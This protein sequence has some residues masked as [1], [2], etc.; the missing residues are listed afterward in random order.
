MNDVKSYLQEI[1]REI[2]KVECDKSTD[3][4][5]EL[6]FAEDS[7]SIKTSFKIGSDSYELVMEKWQT[8]GPRAY[9]SNPSTAVNGF[10]HVP[11]FGEFC[12]SP[13]INYQ[14]I[15]DRDRSFPMFTR[16][17]FQKRPLPGIPSFTPDTPLA[18]VAS[19]DQFMQD[20]YPGQAFQ[21]QPSPDATSEF[22]IQSDIQELINRYANLSVVDDDVRRY[23]VSRLIEK[24]TKDKITDFVKAERVVIAFVMSLSADTDPTLKDRMKR[25]VII[26]MKSTGWVN[27]DI[28]ETIPISQEELSSIVSSFSHA[29]LQKAV[30]ELTARSFNIRS[31]ASRFNM[32]HGDVRALLSDKTDKK[33]A[34]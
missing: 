19:Y 6:S 13:N 2:T 30:R 12:P 16:D 5:G 9:K 24:I 33:S 18:N 25:A 3:V 4:R 22:T 8:G 11:A 1:I 27:K 21:K 10:P 32:S 26:E 14:S 28:I 29:E 23:I 31:I 17:A 15:L 7:F 34:S 20:M